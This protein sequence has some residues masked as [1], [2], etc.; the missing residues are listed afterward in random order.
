MVKVASGLA[1]GLGQLACGMVE[2]CVGGWRVDPR[3]SGC[4]VR[5]DTRRECT[6]ASTVSTTYHC[7]RRGGGGLGLRLR[8][9]CEGALP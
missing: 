7:V 6:T 2:V 9:M 5:M 4:G 3:P 1:A 8:V